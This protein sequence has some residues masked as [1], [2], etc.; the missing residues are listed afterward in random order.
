MLAVAIR[1]IREDN[2][3]RQRISDAEERVRDYPEKPQLAWVLAQTKLESYL[4]RNLAQVKAIFFLTSFVMIV[5]F[6]FVLFGIVR[7]FD[8]PD[9]LPV[10][11]VA[12]VSGL[13]INFIGG[14]FLLVYR[15]TLAQSTGY[16][17]VLERINAVGM[18]VQVLE[19]IPPESAE[20][21][22]ATTADIA[23]QLLRLYSAQ[24]K[25]EP[26]N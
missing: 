26:V 1:R 10:A 25:G 4:N 21:K 12:S 7:A 24:P 23:K 5:G 14:S 15:S 11:I 13:L 16:V 2:F 6:C 19:S 20:L 22:S 8:S 17:A 9:K 3:F 18:A